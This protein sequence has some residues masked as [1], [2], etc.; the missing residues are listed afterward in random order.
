M[1]RATH[2]RCIRWHL[3]IAFKAREPTRQ[4]RQATRAMGPNSAAR[5]IYCPPV[6]ELC[7]LVNDTPHQ[8]ATVGRCLRQW[9]NIP[10]MLAKK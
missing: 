7:H 5:L 9:G 3:T 6:G 8:A 10:S 2:I 1:H 4:A